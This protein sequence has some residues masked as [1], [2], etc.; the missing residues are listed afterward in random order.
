MGESNVVNIN[1]KKN[2]NYNNNIFL[3]SHLQKY[4]SARQ[5]KKKINKKIKKWGYKSKKVFRRLLKM[6]I[7]EAYLILIGIELH[8][9]GPAI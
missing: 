6:V 8:S 7:E 1:I 4:Q 5:I 3:L 2:I 9:L